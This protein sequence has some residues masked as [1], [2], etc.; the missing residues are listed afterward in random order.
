MW[1]PEAPK[2]T[3]RNVAW[4]ICVSVTVAVLSAGLALV[5][6]AL[7]LVP[8]VILALAAFY[9]IGGELWN[10]RQNRLNKIIPHFRGE[11]ADIAPR[12]WEDDDEGGVDDPHA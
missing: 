2:M 10:K 12:G 11:T 6:P 9:L 4:A 3:G 5:S 1:I 8:N 7:A